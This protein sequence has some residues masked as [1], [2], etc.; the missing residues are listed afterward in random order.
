MDEMIH[1][2]QRHLK[3]YIE[4][5]KKFTGVN[6]KRECQFERLHLV[7]DPYKAFWDALIKKWQDYLGTF[8]RWWTP[9]F[10]DPSFKDDWRAIFMIRKIL[11]RPPPPS[12]CWENFS[13]NPVILSNWNLHICGYSCSH[14]WMI[15]TLRWGASFWRFGD[16]ILVFNRTMIL[17]EG[18]ILI[19]IKQADLVISS[20]CCQS[21]I[22]N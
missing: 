2:Q 21:T 16:V 8:P 1:V 4:K 3:K 5:M 13:N 11:R 22:S 6:K 7:S 9:H 20:K 19:W 15:V 18:L 17:K 14:V 12:P 10:G